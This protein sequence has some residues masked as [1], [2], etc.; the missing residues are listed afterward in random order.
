M[1]NEN[2]VVEFPGAA[3]VVRRSA[4]LQNKRAP[5]QAID[6]N[7]APPKSNQQKKK[8]GRPKVE[9]LTFT[10]ILLMCFRATVEEN[11]HEENIQCEQK[12]GIFV[13]F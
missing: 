10:F 6:V 2:S 12:E 4:R 9:T 3:K 1:E 13:D 11:E 8:R 5:L 7:T